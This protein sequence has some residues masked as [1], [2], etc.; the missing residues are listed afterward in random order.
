M[1]HR[2]HPGSARP[3]V[4]PVDEP[5]VPIVFWIGF[6]VISAVAGASLIFIVVLL[7]IWSSEEDAARRRL[8]EAEARVAQLES[9]LAE[10]REVIESQESA[11]REA[12][13]LEGELSRAHSTVRQ[14]RS[15]LTEA[16]RNPA[17]LPLMQTRAVLAR[18]RSVRVQVQL[19][20]HAEAAGLDEADLRDAIATDLNGLT[21]DGDAPFI[22]E[23]VVNRLP[24]S[25]GTRGNE[26][27]TEAIFIQAKIYERMRIP[28]SEHSWWAVIRDYTLE[29]RA[30]EET[31]LSVAEEAVKRMIDHVVRD[32]GA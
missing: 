11:L 31:S 1:T 24:D 14:L 6:A 7:L 20:R 25:A 26:G 22:L 18:I 8:P 27:A 16:R 28:D 9:S 21:V 3:D 17:E 2:R 13:A 4:P 19:D 10:A 5:K 23:I 12:Q 29:E 32:I 30:T 15:Q